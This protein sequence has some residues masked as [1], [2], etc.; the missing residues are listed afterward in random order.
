[1]KVRYRLGAPSKEFTGLGTIAT[2]EWV[3]VSDKATQAFKKAHGKTLKEAGF[4]V[5]TKTKEND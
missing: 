3:E 5:D 4:E 2:N 1:M